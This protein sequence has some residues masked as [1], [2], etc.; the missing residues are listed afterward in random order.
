MKGSTFLL[1]A[2]VGWRVGRRFGLSLAIC[3]AAG[4]ALAAPAPGRRPAAV[5]EAGPRPASQET[6]SDLASRLFDGLPE[7][8]HLHLVVIDDRE[9][10]YLA[11]H[12][13]SWVGVSELRAYWIP[14]A[15]ARDV[16]EE[17]AA[18]DHST[19]FEMLVNEFGPRSKYVSDIGLDGIN[20]EEVAVGVGRLQDYFSLRQFDTAAEADVAYREWLER[21]LEL[22]G[23]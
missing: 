1:T 2:G 21:A 7:S 14:K 19:A 18:G 9:R 4:V 15:E 12:L 8:D 22:T 3:L 6:I 5:S 11:F 20:S 13:S 17:V 10:V 23:R 16:S